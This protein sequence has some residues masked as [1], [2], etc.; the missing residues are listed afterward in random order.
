M[1]RGPLAGTVSSMGYETTNP[2]RGPHVDA[3]WEV[4]RSAVNWELSG[5]LDSPF[6]QLLAQ[7]V[8]HNLEEL[9]W[10]VVRAAEGD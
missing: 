1:P 9:G 6:G 10:R 8:L 7:E 3:L 5:E 2:L 4:L